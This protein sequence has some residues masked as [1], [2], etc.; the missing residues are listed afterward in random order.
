MDLSKPEAE[1][2]A[3]IVA[4]VGD[5]ER[6]RLRRI[7]VAACVG[8]LTVGLAVV[9]LV[10]RWPWRAFVAFT[11]T[12]VVALVGGLLLIERRLFRRSE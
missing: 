2:F 9:V 10:L 5:P 12:F 8:V 1:L 7:V 3:S 6:R 4:R 11:V